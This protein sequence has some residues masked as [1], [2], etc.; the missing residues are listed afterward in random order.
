[1]QPDITTMC[2]YR[3]TS[4]GVQNNHDDSYAQRRAYMHMQVHA[5]DLTHDMKY[6]GMATKDLCPSE[7]GCQGWAHGHTQMRYIKAGMMR[8]GRK[9]RDLCT[10]EEGCQEWAHGHT[11]MQYIKAGMMYEGTA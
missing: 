7:E 10:P 8:K 3:F 6:K 5:H 1:M 2:A 9:T 11:Q 4:Y